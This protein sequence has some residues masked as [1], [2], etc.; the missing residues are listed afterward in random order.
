MFVS[1]FCLNVISSTTFCV[2]NRCLKAPLGS[3]WEEM[4][5]RRTWCTALVCVFHIATAP[6]SS[7][8]FFRHG[9]DGPWEICICPTVQSVRNQTLEYLESCPVAI[10]LI[11]YQWWKRW[12]MLLISR[13]RSLPESWWDPMGPTPSAHKAGVSGICT[14]VRWLLLT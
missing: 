8:V 4:G 3:G 9:R 12:F 1:I 5:Q 2:Q 13:R 6:S 7:V 14:D 10:T 11:P